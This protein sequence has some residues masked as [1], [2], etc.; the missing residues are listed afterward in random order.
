MTSG[1]YK[2]TEAH[3]MAISK[4]RPKF[5]NLS[6]KS[7]LCKSL[8]MKDYWKKHK[9]GIIK[10]CKQCTNNFYV[11]P[12]NKD[13]KHFCNKLCYRLNQ[14]GKHQTPETIR[15]RIEKLKG[16]EI[17][18]KDKISKSLKGH[19][20]SNETREKIS[21]AN[22]VHGL[23]KIYSGKSLYGDDW[24]KIRK[25]VYMRD[26]YK[27]QICFK[28]LIK[29]DVHHKIPFLLC[30]DNSLSNLISLC[31]KCHTVEENKL[32]RIHKYEI[33]KIRALLYN[34]V[35]N[36]FKGKQTDEELE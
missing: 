28:S 8:K 22:F 27:C 24:N 15:K 25:L 20:V 17:L 29:L 3:R 26:N 35:I 21:K 4:S 6:K 30:F 32:K 14:I 2:R 10:S 11:Q 13:N 23:S 33:S 19:K 18:W 9:H 5:I 7:R 1:I 34:K 12:C 36:N 31:R 16:R